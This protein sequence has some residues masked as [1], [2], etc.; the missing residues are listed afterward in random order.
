M[1]GGRMLSVKEVADRIGRSSTTVRN[2]I[3]KGKLRAINVGTGRGYRSWSVPEEAL[4]DFM[5]AG[6]SSAILQMQTR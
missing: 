5:K 2:L 3:E 6:E 1:E 4:L